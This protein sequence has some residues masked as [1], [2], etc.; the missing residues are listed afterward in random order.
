MKDKIFNNMVIHEDHCPR[1]DGE[2][3]H[4]FQG[5][6]ECMKCFWW[7]WLQKYDDNRGGTW[8]KIA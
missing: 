3:W 8:V 1:C 6:V 4:H 2:L 5:M 7:G